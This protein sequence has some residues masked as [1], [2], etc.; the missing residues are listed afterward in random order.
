MTNSGGQA[1]EAYAYTSYGTP[2]IIDP[3]NGTIRT[4]STIGNR[5]LFTAREW[6][7]EI[8]TYHFRY[9]TFEPRLNLFMSRWTSPRFVGAGKGEYPIP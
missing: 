2:T 8:Q 9:R 7:K 6:D 4:S 3:S 1:V 5:W